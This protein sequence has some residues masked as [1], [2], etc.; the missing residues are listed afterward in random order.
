MKKKMG[1][2]RNENKD[3]RRSD[4]KKQVSFPNA[5]ISASNHQ[6][7]ATR[8]VRDE[9]GGF[10]LR[11]VDNTTRIDFLKDKPGEMT[12]G[13]QIALY[14]MKRYTWYNPQ[15]ETEGSMRKISR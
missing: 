5:A 11:K 13:R 2:M 10:A 12:Y 1:I 14:L 7:F 15:L 4:L 9:D 8:K 6:L 3:E